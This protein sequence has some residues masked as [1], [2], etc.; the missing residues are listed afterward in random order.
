MRFRKRTT[1]R[2]SPRVAR[3]SNRLPVLREQNL[4]GPGRNLGMPIIRTIASPTRRAFLA[5]AA[6]LGTAVIA[7]PRHVLAR[8][9]SDAAWRGLAENLRGRLLRPGHA[10]FASTAAPF[11]LRYADVL[12]AGIAVCR[13]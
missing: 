11:N 6:A 5:G 2:T 10:G 7:A 13:D 9:P 1:A 3:H 4:Q 8:G 12:P